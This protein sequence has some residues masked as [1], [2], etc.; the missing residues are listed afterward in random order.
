MEKQHDATKTELLE[1]ISSLREGMEELTVGT[2]G[3]F[4]V[5]QARPLKER[6]TSF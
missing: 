4:Q 5:M 3:R 1:T 2:A 6:K